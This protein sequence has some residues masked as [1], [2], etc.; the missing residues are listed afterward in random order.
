MYNLEASNTKEFKCEVSCKEKACIKP[1]EKTGL[2]EWA[3]RISIGCFH[4]TIQSQL[5]NL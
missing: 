4:L 3:A 5:L 2:S 1:N